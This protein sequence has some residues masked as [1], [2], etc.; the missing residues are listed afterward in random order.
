MKAEPAEIA[1]GVEVYLLLHPELAYKDV[2][3]VGQTSA[4]VMRSAVYL[5]SEAVAER[6]EA[7]CEYID[8]FR[9]SINFNENSLGLCLTRLDTEVVN[10]AT[11]R[12]KYYQCAGGSSYTITK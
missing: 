4:H 5:E 8:L 11:T 9:P 6:A 1:E 12:H 3:L 2:D 7:A 10:D